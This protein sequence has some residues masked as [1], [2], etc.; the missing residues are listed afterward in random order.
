MTNSD[1]LSTDEPDKSIQE[2]RAEILE[3]RRLK[4]RF[5]TRIFSTN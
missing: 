4:L 1:H 3:C 2:L 5:E